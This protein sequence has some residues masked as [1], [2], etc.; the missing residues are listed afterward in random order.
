M[1]IIKTFFYT[2]RDDN[3][4][5]VDYLF[6]FNRIDTN[7]NFDLY[8]ARNDMNTLLLQYGNEPQ[9]YLSAPLQYAFI[10]QHGHIS[11]HAYTLLKHWAFFE[12]LMRPFFS[13]SNF[14]QQMNISESN[15]HGLFAD[16]MNSYLFNSEENYEQ[17]KAH[18]ENKF[19]IPIDTHIVQL[20]NSFNPEHAINMIAFLKQQYNIPDTPSGP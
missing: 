15:A 9:E 18:F 4:D 20:W 6:S 14:Y 7:Q 19:S 2:E 5:S 10:V 11:D 13:H 3:N 16:I 17:A 1:N 12:P 8:L